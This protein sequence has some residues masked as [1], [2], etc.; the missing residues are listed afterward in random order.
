VASKDIGFLKIGQ[1]VQFQM[2]AF[3]YNYFGGLVGK[4]LAID[5][6]YTLINNT[7]MFK[8]KCGIDKKLLSLKNGYTGQLKKGLNFQARFKVTNRSLWQLLFDKLDDWLNPIKSNQ[9]TAQS[10]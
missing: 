3:D 6:D 1:P 7:A 8:V 2:E 10:T 4:I 5:N 9:K